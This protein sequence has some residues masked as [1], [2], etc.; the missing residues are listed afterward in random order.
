MQSVSVRVFLITPGSVRPFPYFFRGWRVHM[1]VIWTAII[2]KI[3][4]IGAKICASVD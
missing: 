3:G 4:K 1:S 2:P